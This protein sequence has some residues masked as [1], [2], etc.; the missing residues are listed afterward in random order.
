MLNEKIIDLQTG[1]ETIREFTEN[2]IAEIE[3]A[4]VKAQAKA[5]AKAIKAHERAALL[6]RLG[7]TA[8]EARLLLGGN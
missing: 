2:E 7:I 6:E 8:E 3:V 4:V 5:E 1:E